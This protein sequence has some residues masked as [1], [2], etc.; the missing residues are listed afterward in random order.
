MSLKVQQLDHIGLNVTNL[1]KSIAFYQALFGFEI[2]EK[3]DVPRQAFIGNGSAVLGL[4]EIANYD[5][6]VYT[7]AHIAFACSQSDFA[8]T[9]TQIKNLGLTIVSGPKAQR[10]GETMLF[11]DPSGNILEICYPSIQN[12]Q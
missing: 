8:D 4:M 11:R 12:R 5:Y 10:G 1:E 2:I 7:M 6:S 9:V 3:W